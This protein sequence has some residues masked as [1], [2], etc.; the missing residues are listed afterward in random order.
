MKA[1]RGFLALAAALVISAAAGKV[2]ARPRFG[3]SARRRRSFEDELKREL[4]ERQGLAKTACPSSE[5]GELA[6]HFHSTKLE[7]FAFAGTRAAL[8]TELRRRS[9]AGVVDVARF[10]DLRDLPVTF[11]PT[12]ALLRGETG[13]AIVVKLAGDPEQASLA[14]LGRL[15]VLLLLALSASGAAC[16]YFAAS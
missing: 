6:S 8:L 9:A 7:V 10:R 2:H 12:W 5:H 1:P 13:C 4:D 14:D 11:Q 16:F 15:D 3:A